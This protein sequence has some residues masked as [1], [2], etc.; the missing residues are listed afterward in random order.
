MEIVQP[1]RYI[2]QTMQQAMETVQFGRFPKDIDI[3]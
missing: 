2:L 3:L 1:I